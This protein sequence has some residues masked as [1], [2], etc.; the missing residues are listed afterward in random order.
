MNGKFEEHDKKSYF[1]REG[2]YQ[3]S[4]IDE[5]DRESKGVE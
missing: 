3:I 4:Y 5:L 1:I 2:I